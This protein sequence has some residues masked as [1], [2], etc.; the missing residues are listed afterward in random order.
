MLECCWRSDNIGSWTDS[1][2]IKDRLSSFRT[3]SMQFQPIFHIECKHSTRALWQN[4]RKSRCNWKDS[5]IWNQIEILTNEATHGNIEFLRY[6]QD[7]SITLKDGRYHAKLPWK[8]DPP[9]QCW[10]V[11]SRKNNTINGPTFGK[12]SKETQDVRWCYHHSR[13]TGIYREGR[14]PRCNFWNLS[15]YTTSCCT[16]GIIY[17]SNTYCV[18]LQLSKIFNTSKLKWLSNIRST[19]L[20]RFRQHKYGLVADIEKAI[21]YVNLDEEDREITRF[22]WLSDPNDPKKSRVAPLKKLN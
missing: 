2:Q 11:E 1:C 12:G 13:K 20:L 17:A 3:C 18:R 6:D 22:L 9:N 10:D 21:L 14:K 5:G 7:T 15:L 16:K 19:I 4:Q 8:Q